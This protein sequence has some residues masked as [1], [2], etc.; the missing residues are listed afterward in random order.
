MSNILVTGGAGF[1]G[2]HLIE[3]LLKQGHQVHVVD[4]LSSNP[5]PVRDLLDELGNPENLTIF[6]EGIVPYFYIWL[7]QKDPP[8][9]DQIYHLASP[10]G[11]AGILQY[12]GRM[13]KEIVDDLDCL[14]EMAIECDA[15]L[16]DVST[17][18]V[19]GG[20]IG[21]LCR[22]DMARIVPAKTTVRLEYA[23]AKLAAET[24]LV[25]TCQ[26]TDLDAVIVRPF[27]VAGP[28]QSSKGGFVLPRFI[29]QATSGQDLTVFGNGSQVRAFTHVGEIADGLMKVME[30]GQR[31]QVYNLGNP[32]N[33]V[34]IRELASKVIARV[35][36]GSASLTTGGRITYADP[37]TIY[38]DLYEESADKYPGQPKSELDWQP[39]KT[40]DDIIE[41]A[42][43]WHER[44]KAR[45]EME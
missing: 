44:N 6:Y 33:R 32:A 27:N 30:R 25:N 9:Y 39:E 2:G 19:Y 5:I 43:R 34:T 4:N 28:R 15:R 18:E 26:V 13:V 29:E 38:G 20:G 17:S 22:E 37:K 10:V 41:D 24:M 1:V 35:G 31:G 3:R 45:T 12:A 14:I 36:R 40:V 8:K 23:V 21:G 42:L 7:S 11:P 16:L